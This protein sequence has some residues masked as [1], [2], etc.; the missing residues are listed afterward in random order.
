[1]RR[2]P[3][4]RN[5]TCRF[6]ASLGSLSAETFVS[7]DCGICIFLSVVRSLLCVSRTD[8]LEY[9]WCRVVALRIATAVFEL[10]SRSVSNTTFFFLRTPFI[11]WFSGAKFR[12]SFRLEILSNVLIDEE[13][14]WMVR[15]T[16]DDTQS[17][18]SGK[19]DN[20]WWVEICGALKE[21]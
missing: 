20:R 2:Y 14:E 4:R 1:M 12:A 18:E 19:K 15:N 17:E 9:G 21:G 13:K 8:T 6:L 10:E 3:H 5:H 11:P 16:S 7:D